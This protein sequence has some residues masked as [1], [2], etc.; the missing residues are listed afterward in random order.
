MRRVSN[1]PM[2]AMTPTGKRM[3]L[4]LMPRAERA[5]ISLSMDMRPRPSM[6]PTSTAMG[7]VKTKTLGRMHRKSCAICEPEPEW[8][9]KRSMR[10]T[11]LGAQGTKVRES[12]ASYFANNIAVENAHGEKG[13]VTWGGRASGVLWQLRK[14]RFTTVDTQSQEE[15]GGLS[16]RVLRSVAGLPNC[17][18]KPAI[19]SG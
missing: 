12:G 18:G 1:A 3:R 13:S 8:R 10:R 19:Q 15:C 7:I 2:R 14:K 6:T 4:R 17:G 11:S 9:T 16:V 5:T